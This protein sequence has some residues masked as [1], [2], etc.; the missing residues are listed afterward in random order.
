MIPLLHA[1]VLARASREERRDAP[2]HLHNRH[3]AA[4]LA[5]AANRVT[6]TR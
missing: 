2:H 3:A 5:A 1:A 4:I 6:P